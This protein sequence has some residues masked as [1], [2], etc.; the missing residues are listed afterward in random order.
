MTCVE[1][2]F[3][4]DVVSVFCVGEVLHP[5]GPEW[6]VQACQLQYVLVPSV[7]RCYH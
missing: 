1:D 2:S 5:P 3:V 7:C 4:K 6:P